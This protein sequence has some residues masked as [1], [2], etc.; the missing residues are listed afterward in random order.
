MNPLRAVGILGNLGCEGGFEVSGSCFL[1]KFGDIAITA[2]HC[3][4]DTT[5]PMGLYFPLRRGEPARITEQII[6]HPSADVAIVK[7]SPVDPGEDGHELFR[8]CALPVGLGHD[9]ATYGFPTEGPIYAGDHKVTPR[10]FKGYLQHYMPYADPAG[11]QYEASEMSIPAPAGLS[12]SPVFFPDQ[13][14]MITGVVT[15]NIES[16]AVIDSVTE[17]D[18]DGRVY[19]ESSK[20]VVAYG[21]ALQLDPLK[22]WINDTSTSLSRATD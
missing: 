13:P 1:Y 21:V 8:E 19:R 22:E 10:L 18:D 4:P 7:T 15:T 3:I 14:E 5:T 9:F 12:G 11:R 2:A 17:V 20:R 16:Y 6:L